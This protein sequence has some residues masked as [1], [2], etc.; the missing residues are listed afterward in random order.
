MDVFSGCFWFCPPCWVVQVGPHILK[1]ILT[2][3]LG[4]EKLLNICLVCHKILKG[5]YANGL[6]WLKNVV[7]YS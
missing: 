4:K 3:Q 2:I 7:K 1:N 5:G 6:M